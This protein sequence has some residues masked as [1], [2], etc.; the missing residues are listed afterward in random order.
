VPLHSV[1]RITEADLRIRRLD[2]AVEPLEPTG[3]TH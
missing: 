3:F 2:G 1:G